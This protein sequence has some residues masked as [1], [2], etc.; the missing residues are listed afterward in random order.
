[1]AEA[2]CCIVSETSSADFDSYVLSESSLF[3][4]ADKLMIKTCG[5]TALLSALP[6]VLK[7][8]AGAGCNL[9]RARY[10]RS[11]FRYA[12]SQPAPHGS[13]AE[14]CD[15]LDDVIGGPEKGMACVLGKQDAGLCWHVY[16]ADLPCSPLSPSTPN[17]TVESNIKDIGQPTLTLEICMTQLCPQRASAFMFGN[18]ALPA[19]ATVTTASGI[20]AIFPDTIIDDF[21]FSPCGYSMNGLRGSS[22]ATIHITPEARCSYA[23]LEVSGTTAD[24]DPA[25]MLRQ[26]LRVFGPGR[27][28]VSLTVDARPGDDLPPL[29][30]AKA[31][32][33]KGYSCASDSR[34]ELPG[35]GYVAF[36]QL[37]QS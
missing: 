2:Q 10:S 26:A 21:L 28:S 27:V 34:V 15:F 11:C 12:D 18:S 25:A 4:Y 32:S 17:G 37:C 33:A 13:W 30:W 3:V 1:M 7:L 19:A 5:T 36:A 16:V 35:G 20:G 9:L 23:S 29:A 22:L 6:A 24:V 14:E 8:A 31:P